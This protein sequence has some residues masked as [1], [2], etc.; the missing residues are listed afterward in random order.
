[1]LELYLTKGLYPKNAV[2][3]DFSIKSKSFYQFVVEFLC[4]PAGWKSY[5]TP[6]RP[7]GV[8]RARGS[9]KESSLLPLGHL[10]VIYDPKPHGYAFFYSHL[11]KG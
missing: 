11:E 7:I 2:L 3:G 4:I 6:R 5:E 8:P 1:V 10:G 9:H